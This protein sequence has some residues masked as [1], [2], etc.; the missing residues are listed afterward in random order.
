MTKKILCLLLALA[1]VLSLT[2]CGNQ[3]STTTTGGTSDVA[4][5]GTIESTGGMS[6]ESTTGTTVDSTTDATEGAASDGTPWDDDGVLKIL[7]I[8]NSFSVDCM[9]YVYQIAKAA[10]VEKI[11]LGNLFVSQKL[12]YGKK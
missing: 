8:G 10:G 1:C 7:T 12:C 2:A 6:V 9:E 11:K 3:E 5:D 4:Q